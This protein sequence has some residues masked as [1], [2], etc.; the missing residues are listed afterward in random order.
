MHNRQRVLRILHS[1]RIAVRSRVRLYEACVRSALVYGLDA[2][3]LPIEV[4]R[5]LDSFDARA[6][7]G[8]AK[9]R[10]I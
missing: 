5:R 10:R 8:I 4:L 6:L 7:R 2:I 3:G 9:S 1:R